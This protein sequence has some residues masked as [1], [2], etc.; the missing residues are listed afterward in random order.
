MKIVT[1]SRLINAAL[2]FGLLTSH[3]AQA[4]GEI[5]I[6]SLDALANAVGLSNPTATSGTKLRPLK[7][8][9]FD[10]GF[11]GFNDALGTTIPEHTR[12][13]KGPVAVDP[14]T[15]Q[16]HGLKI[17]EIFSNLMD[18]T[19]VPYELHL[20]QAFGY[21]NLQSAIDTAIV[22]KFDLVLYS[23]VW[24]YAGNG[25]GE[26]FINQL[27]S[28]ATARGITWV[29]ASGNFGKST[30]RAAVTRTDDDWARLPGPNQS[31][32][33]RCAKNAGNVCHLRVVLAWNSFS[34]DVNIGTD[35]DLDLV[36][37]DDTLTV[38]KTA[39]LAQKKIVKPEDQ[40]ASLYPREIVEVDV[41]PGLYYARVKIRSQN[42]SKADEL[43]LTS[44]GDFTQMLNPTLGETLL[45]PA[46]N[47]SVITVGAFDAEE[48]GM[49]RKLLRPDLS[50]ISL[51]ELEDG[52]LFKGSSQSAAAYAARIAFEI[53][54]HTT[55][56]QPHLDRASV[57]QLARGGTPRPKP[58]P[59]AE[60]TR[61]GGTSAVNSNSGL[62]STTGSCYVYVAL[63]LTTPGARKMLRDGGFAV[64]TVTG[65]KVFIDE[66]PFVRAAR[67]GIIIDGAPQN[68]MGSILAADV[69]GFF[70]VPIA[71]R[72]ELGPDAVEFV[73][74]P[75]AATY[76]PIR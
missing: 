34:N 52:A 63:P 32:Q 57:L 38:V 19:E 43:R 73:Q 24:E 31:V 42:F 21:S 76:C 49:S 27:V 6:E 47:P 36:L 74:T 18:R 51:I 4:A 59:T 25:D 60:P 70:A 26:G 17:A 20:F 44:S 22:E 11:Q 30:Y 8:A 28:N 46:D 68:F 35:K 39:G 58:L 67:M 62:G 16:G 75:R 9:I 50:A 71:R 72:Q 33:I 5:R 66:N 69:S 15:E 61:G 53:S 54:K 12:L 45:A 55:P 13:R 23:Q 3:S 56:D 2:L 64:A 14:A 10:N 1:I 48:T 37:T 65:N 41:K 7:V 40:G 29:N